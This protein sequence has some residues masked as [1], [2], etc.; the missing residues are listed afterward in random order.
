MRRSAETLTSVGNALFQAGEGLRELDAGGWHGPATDA[1]HDYFDGEPARWLTSG[2]AFHHAAEAL[3]SYAEVFDW[4]QREAEHAAVVWEHGRRISEQALARY[5]ADAARA[6]A[7]AQREGAPTPD[8]PFTDPGQQ[9]REAAHQQLDRA[10][11]QL[12]EAGNRAQAAVAGARDQAPTAPTLVEQA[13]TFVGEIGGGIGAAATEAASFIGT[14]SPHHLITDPAQYG[15]DMADLAS[16]IKAAATHP[17]SFT[18]PL[19]TG[20]PGP[21][22]PGVHWVSSLLTERSP[23][24]PSAPERPS[25]QRARAEQPSRQHNRATGHP[26]PA[27]LQ[28]EIWRSHWPRKAR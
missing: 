20:T 25:A 19:W 9:L 8:L 28:D 12:Q 10:R 27:R 7:Q 3:V 1:F 14:I 17:V 23:P 26:P 4:A 5:Q 22:I 13:A 21:E 6:E 18:K 15:Q 11:Q 2:D 16:G 24:E